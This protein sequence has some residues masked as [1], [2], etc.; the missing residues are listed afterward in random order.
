LDH[1]LLI[2]HKAREEV[3]AIPALPPQLFGQSGDEVVAG[4][5]EG[6]DNRGWKRIDPAD[7]A[8]ESGVLGIPEPSI[9]VDHRGIDG[10]CDHRID[11]P[12]PGANIN[13]LGEEIPDRE[14]MSLKQDRRRKEARRAKGVDA[15]VALSLKFAESGNAAGPKSGLSAV[16]N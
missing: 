7:H 16:V 11:L 8:R 10:A 1:V 12:L 15:A 3:G 14:P 9:L 5:G 2:G 13:D 4:C 6:D